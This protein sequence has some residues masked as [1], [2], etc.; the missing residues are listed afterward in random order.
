[1]T[2][3]SLSSK[4]YV[5]YFTKKLENFPTNHH[6][7]PH[8]YYNSLQGILQDVFLHNAEHYQI[9]FFGNSKQNHLYKRNI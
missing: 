6:F 7:S 9:L 3:A 2:F 1:M 8:K 4:S 5:E